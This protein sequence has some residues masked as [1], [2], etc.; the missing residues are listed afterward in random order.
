MGLTYAEENYLKSILKLVHPPKKTVNTNALAAH[1]GTSAP[2]ITDM[3][4][5]LADKHLITYQRYHGASLTEE[6]LRL[7]TDLV[8]KHR[9]WEVFLHHSLGMSWEEIH[10]IAEELE[11]IQSNRLIECLDNFLGNPKFDP[12]GDPIPNAQ[13]KYTMR[14]QI[15]LSDLAVGAAGTIVGVKNDTPSFLRHLTE[16]GIRLGQSIRVIQQDAYDH[17]ISLTVDDRST[18]L[19]GPVATNIFVKPA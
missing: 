2:S 17:S 14:T 3:L 8:R 10:A 1:L 6:G 7:A 4:K 12:H 16:K 5:K 9:L 18:E 13:G 15:P 19:S 11:H